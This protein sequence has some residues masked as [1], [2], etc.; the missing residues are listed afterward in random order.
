MIRP[1]ATPPPL[2]KSRFAYGRKPPAMRAAEVPGI[3]SVRVQDLFDDIPDPLHQAGEDTTPVRE[4]ATQALAAVDMSMIK[5]GDTVN[6][7]CSEHGF[8]MMGG[9]AY[10]ELL[11]T[12]RDE[13]VRRTGTKKVR[14]A[15]SAANSKF[16]QMEIVPRFG[17]DEH[18]EDQVFTFGPYDP[19]VA[20]DTEIGRLYGVRRAYAAQWLIHVHYDDPRELHF[21]HANGRLLKAFTMSYARMETRSIFHNNFP[22][23][24]ANIVP[25]AIYESP[26]IR[27]RWAF[28][29]V[30]STSPTGTMGVDA[31]ND[32]IAMDRRISAS[33]LRR[34]GK[35][36]ELFRTIDTCFSIADDTRW[37]PYQHAGGLTQCALFENGEDHLDLGLPDHPPAHK[38]D[39]SKVTVV[40]GPVRAIVMNYAW[41]L[42]TTANLT[43]AADADV[44][45]DLLR[46]HP[47]SQILVAENLPQAIDIAIEETGTDM[48]IVF[49]GCYGAINVTRPLAERL[50]AAAPAIAD[51]VDEQ[52]LPKWLGQRNLSL[53]A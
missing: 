41:K 39:K 36:L 26:Y 9:D 43:V 10:A 48:G 35:M 14:L 52:L 15:M 25:R 24:S 2:G 49:D 3:C 53:A 34:Y 16:E 5:A 19:G 6:V 28:S 31:D 51:R 32:L 33:M 20:I 7:L 12:V 29:A 30:L 13:V 11:R 44:G 22:T 42:F 40:R 23:R 47:D 21:H 4:A 1:A 17:L 38:P 27:E 37:L 46:I 50:I 18:F 45:K 8:A